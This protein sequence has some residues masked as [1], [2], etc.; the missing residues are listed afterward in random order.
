MPEAL[1]QNPTFPRS[2]EIFYPSSTD[3]K[4]IRTLKESEGEL[5]RLKTESEDEVERLKA[6]IERLKA[7]K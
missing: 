2:T 5:E 4:E 3:D 6:E 1:E 7:E